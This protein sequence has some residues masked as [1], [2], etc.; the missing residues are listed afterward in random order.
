MNL[1]RKAEECSR[2]RTKQKVAP[3]PSSRR[4]S[5]RPKLPVI[6]ISH[7]T[8][9]RHSRILTP[10]SRRTEINPFVS[11]SA[12]VKLEED[13]QQSDKDAKADKDAKE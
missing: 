2:L 5:I 13:E 1:R 4:K 11:E 7:N 12:T 8:A 9:F 6:G 10:K 3:V